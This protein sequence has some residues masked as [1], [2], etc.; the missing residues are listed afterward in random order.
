MAKNCSK[1]LDIRTLIDVN[2]FNTTTL[3]EKKVYYLDS[4]PT[5]PCAFEYY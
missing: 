3:T 4:K 5:L 1:K 2:G